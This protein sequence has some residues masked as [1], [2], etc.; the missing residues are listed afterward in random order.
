MSV[1]SGRARAEQGKGKA[2]G[3]EGLGEEGRGRDKEAQGCR[4][5]LKAD[6]DKVQCQVAWE[7]G[8]ALAMQTRGRHLCVRRQ[9][10]RRL[11]K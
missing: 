9:T 2:K 11:R 1:Q 7:E 3:K 4:P 8:N 10:R 6:F 5:A